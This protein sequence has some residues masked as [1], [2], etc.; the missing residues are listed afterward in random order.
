LRA[1]LADIV[2][3]SEDA[4]FGR[5]LDGTVSSWNRAAERIFGY[6]AEEIIGRSSNVL[7]PLDRPEEIRRLMERIRRG[8]R[9]EHF[10][11]V[12]L[13]KD[14]ERLALSMCV[15]PIRNTRGRI[16]GASTIAR[17]I[18][19][20][21]ELEARL[22]EAGEE[23]RQRLGRDLHDG[24]GQ[25]LGGM[26]LLCRTLMRSLSKRGLPEARTARLLVS[27]IQAATRQTRALARGLT[28]VMDRPNGL[29]LALEDFATTT[30]ILFRINCTFHCEE[31]VL[32][33]DRGAAIHLF[34]IAQEAVSNAIRH[35]HAR[36]VNISLRRKVKHLTLEVRDRGRG[37][38]AP[39]PN[40]TGL[41]L[42]IMKYRAAMLGGTLHLAGISPRGAVVT[43]N[44]P[45]ARL[46]A[47]VP[48]L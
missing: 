28:P 37:L 46:N 10:E 3:S 17:D 6:S 15:S 1:L 41:G 8:A 9:V 18:T 36:R 7:L 22:L 35:G 29:M 42:R 40:P 44:V 25:Q 13:R 39:A 45:L 4:I 12:R 21:R 23:E 24:L 48:H 2:E 14:G 43:C 32:I 33:A 31:P 47:V 11:T 20:E 5:N 26:E 16:V 30:R 19:R 38:A 34:R 27:Q